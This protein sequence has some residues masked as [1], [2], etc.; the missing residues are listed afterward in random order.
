LCLC[1]GME[2]NPT[3]T[4]TKTPITTPTPK[5]NYSHYKKI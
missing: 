2:L 3:Q 1:F 4:P 5:N